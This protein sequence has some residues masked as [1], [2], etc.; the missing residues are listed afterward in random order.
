LAYLVDTSILLRLANTSDVQYPVAQHAVFMLHRQ[1]ETLSTTPQN[2]IEFRSGATRPVAD[3]GLGFTPAVVEQ[4]AAIFE[5][6]FP[7]LPETPDIYPAWKTL[8]QAA[9]VIGK[10][11]HDARLV[12]ICHVYG[13]THVLAFNIRHFARFV[14]VGPGLVV[15]DPNKVS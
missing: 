12:A 5:T 14:G 10:Q 4:K 1:G 8:V 2:L 6:L 15:V 13:I 9:R 11:V 3:N 7:L